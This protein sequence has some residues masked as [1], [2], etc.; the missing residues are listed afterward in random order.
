MAGVKDGETIELFD[1]FNAHIFSHCPGDISL[2]MWDGLHDEISF[3]YPH[4]DNGTVVDVM[5]ERGYYLAQE[6]HEDDFIVKWWRTNLLRHRMIITNPN[7]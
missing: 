3:G 6:E 1:I 7:V 2:K 4:I 5:M